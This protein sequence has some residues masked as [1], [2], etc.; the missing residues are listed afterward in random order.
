[1]PNSGQFTC[2]V[3]GFDKLSTP[4]YDSL[5][6]ASFEICPSCGTEFGY[7]DARKSHEGLRRSWIASG[8]HWQ[9]R[10]ANAPPG[11]NATEQLRAA[12]LLGSPETPR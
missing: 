6:N 2:P 1:M 8:A 7:D 4:A 10:S 3:C 12:G 5:G 11:W 9:S